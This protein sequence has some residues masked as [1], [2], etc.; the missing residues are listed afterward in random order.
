MIRKAGVFVVLAFT[1]CGIGSDGDQPPTPDGPKSH[2]LCSVGIHTQGTFTQGQPRPI[3]PQ[4]GVAQ[5]GCWPDGTWNFTASIAV[6][7]AQAPP[8]CQPPGFAA[9][10]FAASYTFTD[11]RTPNDTG[12]L[13]VDNFAY[14]PGGHWTL[15]VTQSGNMYCDAGFML[16][17]ADGKEVWNLH[18]SLDPVTNILS[19]GSEYT[20]YDIDQ[21][22]NP[23]PS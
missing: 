13:T 1:G 4:T 20:L 21:W 5:E 11:M 14:A 23:P 6:D 7:S 3:D 22:D 9:P 10:A 19:G 12:E 18:P 8:Q 15:K 2:V 17:S 16:Y